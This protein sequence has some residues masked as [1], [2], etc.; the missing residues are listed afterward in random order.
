MEKELHLLW[1]YRMQLQIKNIIIYML[2]AGAISL[3]GL[4]A[5]LQSLHNCLNNTDWATRKAAADALSTLA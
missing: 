1:L 4:K 5:R 3:Q 2:H